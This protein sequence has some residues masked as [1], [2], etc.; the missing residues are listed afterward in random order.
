MVPR[1]VNGHV[2]HRATS[3]H[4]GHV[5]LSGDCGD[6]LWEFCRIPFFSS[7]G[8]VQDIHSSVCM[9]YDADSELKLL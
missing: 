6:I 5:S 4:V 8:E 2:T 7:H 1:M 3:W 9:V